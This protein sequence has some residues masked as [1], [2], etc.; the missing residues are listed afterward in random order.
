M[1]ICAGLPVIRW[2][3]HKFSPLSLKAKLIK[4]KSS[5]LQSW[6]N[7]IAQKGLPSG[8]LSYDFADPILVRR[9]RFD[10]AWPD[11]L[12]AELSQPVALLINEESETMALA[13]QAGFRCF[14]DIPSFKAYVQ[15]EVLAM[16]ASV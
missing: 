3:N 7:W 2:Q 6:N 4:M 1:A 9:W 10:L 5:N 16:E 15:T 12:Q 8:E 14:T 13:S 11:G